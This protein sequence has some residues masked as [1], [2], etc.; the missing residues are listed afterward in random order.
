MCVCGGGGEGYLSFHDG[1]DFVGLLPLT[2][3]AIHIYEG[4]EGDHICS[5]TFLPHFVVGLQ[6]QGAPPTLYTDIHQSLYQERKHIATYSV[7]G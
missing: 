4:I 5:T 1:W 6:G 7:C 2:H 3:L